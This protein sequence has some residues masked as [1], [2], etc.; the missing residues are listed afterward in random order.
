M[1][2][3]V[4]NHRKSYQSVSQSPRRRIASLILLVGVILVGAQLLRSRE[5]IV[6]ATIVLHVGDA[7]WASRVEVDMTPAAGGPPLAH[8]VWAV[9]GP[10]VSL[11]TH[12]P[13]GQYQAQVT[14]TADLRSEQSERT[15]YIA[16]DAVVTLDLSATAPPR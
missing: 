16:R 10:E 7:P 1:D 15:V 5:H 8:L 13:P 14:L 9:S 11:K 6:D 3:S 4:R 2:A 12:L